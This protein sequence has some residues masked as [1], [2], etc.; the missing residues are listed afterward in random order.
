MELD[1]V[2]LNRLVARARGGDGAAFESLWLLFAPKVAAYVRSRGV[3]SVDDVTSEV[4]LGAFSGLP[5]FY[6][7]GAAF[8]SWLFTLAH[9]KSVDAFRRARPESPYDPADDD[10]LSA[11]AEDEAMP[12][13]GLGQLESALKNLPDAQREV[14]LLRVLADLSVDE[15]ARLIGRTPAATRQLQK[16][17]VANLRRSVDPSS[18]ADIRPLRAVP[19]R[20]GEA[21]A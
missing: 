10:R 4:F 14:L 8:R 13:L 3:R 5:G 11:S 17:A 18:D 1:A 21:I 16:R 19:E 7:D 2:D 12:R 6:G 15:I 9:H 20:L